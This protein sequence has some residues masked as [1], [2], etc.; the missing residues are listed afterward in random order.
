MKG[1]SHSEKGEGTPF[2]V[3]AEGSAELPWSWTEETT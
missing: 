1:K 2:D 3:L